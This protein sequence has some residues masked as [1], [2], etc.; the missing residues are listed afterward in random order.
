M[1]TANP[2]LQFSPVETTS[3][4]LVCTRDGFRCALP[5]LRASLDRNL[6]FRCRT[7]LGNSLRFRGSRCNR[8]STPRAQQREMPLASFSQRHTS[9]QATI[10]FFVLGEH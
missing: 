1:K 7:L 2:M 6:S 8:F 9:K 3:V 4:K 5:I 10:C